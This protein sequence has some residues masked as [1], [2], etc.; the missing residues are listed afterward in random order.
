MI[1]KHPAAIARCSSVDD[2]RHALSLAVEEGLEVSVRGGGH[3]V[4]GNALT[5]GGLV[6][7]LSTL[8]NV[9]VD[10][11]QRTAKSEPGA[12]WFDF[13]RAT[14]EFWLATP[15]GVVSSTGVAGLTLGGGIGYLRG[16]HGLTCDNLIA[17][18]VLT[19]GG[20]LLA[21][22]AENHPDLFWALKGG[23]GNFGIVTQFEFR[24]H[25][26][27]ELLAGRVAFPLSEAPR[28][29]DRYREITRVGLPELACNCVFTSTPDGSPVVSFAVSYFGSREKAGAVMQPM[30]ELPA[31]TN[32]TAF[33][34]YC[35][36]QAQLD[37][38]YPPGLRHYWKSTF[39]TGLDS[40]FEDLLMERMRSVPSVRTTLVIEQLHGAFSEI[41]PDATAFGHRG[42]KYNFLIESK[43]E[44]PEQDGENITWT[45]DFFEE[46]QDFSSGSVYINYLSADESAARIRSAYGPQRYSRLAKIKSEYDPDNVFH[47]NQNIPPSA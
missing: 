42:A 29:V 23:G 28:V 7:D 5:D 19:A 6:I 12:R 34:T 24:L 40:R 18:Q 27:R 26:V 1:E 41:S 20:D 47:L 32:Q 38:I 43:W 45:R 46:L 36:A 30:L 44:R 21:V 22:D 16:L 39:V 31:G 3:N 35:A 13:D 17:A 37:P 33:K 2:A 10:P 15:G 25:V 9:I 14:Q 11:V 4:A 8:R